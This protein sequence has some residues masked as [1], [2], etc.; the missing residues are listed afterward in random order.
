MFHAYFLLLARY[1][2]NVAK[3]SIWEQCKKKYRSDRR[4]TDLYLAHIWEISNGHISARGRPIHFMFG[5]T[6]GF[7]GRRIEWRYFRFRQIQD[8]PIYSVFGSRTGFSSIG[9]CGYTRTYASIPDPIR[10]RG[11]GSG[12]VDSSR[13]RV[14]PLIPEK[15]SSQ[16]T[17]LLISSVVTVCMVIAWQGLLT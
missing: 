4:P 13:V 11:Y 2:P 10:T 8:H 15:K 1:V 3:R 7:R 6:V 16:V 12:R 9:D 5:S 14:Y 17:Q